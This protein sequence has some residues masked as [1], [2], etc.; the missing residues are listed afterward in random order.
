MNYRI[1]DTVTISNEALK[2]PSNKIIKNSYIL[3]EV[4]VYSSSERKLVVNL[5]SDKESNIGQVEKLHSSY[6]FKS[7]DK[8]IKTA[9]KADTLLFFI[10]LSLLFVFGEMLYIKVRGDL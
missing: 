8:E 7:V 9:D 1:G 10:I 4:G 2:T 6:E 5:L 3:D